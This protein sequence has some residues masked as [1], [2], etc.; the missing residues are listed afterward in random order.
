VA[1]V[2]G[3]WLVIDQSEMITVSHD[4]V[5]LIGAAVTTIGRRLIPA[6]PLYAG[7]AAVLATA[8]GI[9]WWAERDTANW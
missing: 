9:W 7:T 1:I 8:F 4:A 2:G 3:V 5:G 6:L